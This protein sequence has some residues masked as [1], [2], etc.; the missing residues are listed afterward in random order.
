MKHKNIACRT[1]PFFLEG[2]ARNDS[3]GTCQ[4]NAP[5]PGLR[6]WPQTLPDDWCGEHP[7]FL[8][9]LRGYQPRAGD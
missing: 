4:R 5:A 2:D 6:F 9:L 3:L 7:L 8:V 1:C